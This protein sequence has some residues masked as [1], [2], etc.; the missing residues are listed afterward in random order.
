MGKRIRLLTPALVANLP[1]PETGTAKRARGSVS[2]AGF[3][4]QE[5]RMSSLQVKVCKVEAIEKHP[6]ADRLSIVTVKGWNSIVGLDQY[7]VGD[8]IVFIPPDCVLP[9]P[10][11][12]KYKLEYLKHNGR[13]GT[14]KLRG[15]VSQ[16]LVLDVPEGKRD[17]DDVAEL[18][19]ITKY[20]V[21]ES[22]SQK[23][24]NP[25]GKKKLNPYFDKY[26][27]I[28]NVKN[29]PDIFKPGDVV[30]VTEKIHGCN[31]RYGTLPIVISRD[32]PFIE[33]AIRWYKKYILKH[34]FEFVYG[35]HNIQLYGMKN[36]YYGE[37]V[38]GRIAK[39]Y[40]LAKIIPPGLILYGEIYGPGIQDM[41]YGIKEIDILFFDAKSG[42]QYLGWDEFCVVCET[43]G[44]KHVPVLASSEYYPGMEEDY[45]DGKSF[46]CPDQMREGC[47][48]KCELE[49]NH[50][51]IGRK[52]LKSVSTEYLTRKGGTE[53]K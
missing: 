8:L 44:L 24:A 27:E 33:R 35:S 46:L 40:N 21:P 14:V 47:V 5:D 45:T 28:E 41:T 10:L 4:I 32:Q 42:G 26:T 19:G 7:K 52:I 49:E 30:V 39:K 9:L 53:F 18:L 50:P 1:T 17:G 48:V 34:K 31:A 2:R 22:P 13:T 37:D 43:F 29:Y 3:F 6:N 20:E 16:G 12:E 25:V 38:W 36:N 15:C 51:L 23:Q 11:I